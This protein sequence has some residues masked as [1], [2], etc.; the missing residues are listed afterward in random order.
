MGNQ[1][2]RSEE[3]G[4]RYWVRTGSRILF[5]LL[6]QLY[7]ERLTEDL[8]LTGQSHALNPDSADSMVNDNKHIIEELRFEPFDYELS[9]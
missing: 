9:N 1:C 3:D 4:G 8:V 6:L 5:A 7:S 2:S